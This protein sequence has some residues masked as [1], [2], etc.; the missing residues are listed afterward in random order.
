[1]SSGG[2]TRESDSLADVVEMLLD[3]GADVDAKD[4]KGW[5]ALICA[6]HWDHLAAVKLLVEKG[7]NVNAKIDGGKTARYN[8]RDKW[9]FPRVHKAPQ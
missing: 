7:A 4:K 3:A 9:V 6:A 1:M 5:T 8:A 2:P